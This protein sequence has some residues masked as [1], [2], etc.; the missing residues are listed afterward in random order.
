MVKDII[1]NIKMNIKKDKIKNINSIYK[2]DYPI[3]LFSKKMYEFDQSI[4][5]FLRN[6]MYYSKE[7]LKKTNYG[8]KVIKLLFSKIC[9]NPKKFLKEKIKGNQNKERIVCDFIA[10]MTDRYAINLYKSFK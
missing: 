6:E 3:V 1:T 10:G 7:V 9:K 2:L 5:K 8:K 4:K